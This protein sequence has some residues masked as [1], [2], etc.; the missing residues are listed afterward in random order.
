MKEIPYSL[1]K[2]AAEGNH[3]ALDEIVHHLQGYMYNLSLR[4]LWHPEDAQDATQEIL[5]RVVT[6][7][8]SFRG[9]SSF[10]T[11]AYR[12]AKNHLINTKKS[13]VELA[14]YTFERFGMDL[15]D[16]S[17]EKDL[18]SMSVQETTYLISEVKIG[19]TLAMLSC[20][21]RESRLTYILG[22][23]LELDSTDGSEIMEC[24]PE[25]FRKRLSR[26]RNSIESFSQQKCGVVNSANRCR[27]A[28]KVSPAID[29]GLVDPKNLLF[30]ESSLSS[31][32][33][34]SSTIKRLEENR[35][36]IAIYRSHPQFKSTKN[37]NEAI[38]R[39]IFKSH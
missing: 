13:R 29:S 7:L 1:V 6:H 16:S 35:E 10:M 34:V 15:D 5:I 37:L 38:K 14:N 31:E 3:E 4:M 26:A 19:C 24:S 11:W 33:E 30:A 21:D 36:L 18:E 28:K 39:L 25:A 9:E 17:G 27:C 23:I 2:I 22:E 12:V 8:G 20:L 32:G